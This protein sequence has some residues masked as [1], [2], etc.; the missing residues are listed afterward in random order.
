[1]ALVPFPNQASPTPV[2][3]DT[4]NDWLD[5]DQGGGGKMSFLE[6]LD[7]LRKR[8]IYSAVAL[9]VGFLIAFAFNNYIFDF[10]MRPLRAPLPKGQMLI[11]TEPM[12]AFTLRIYMSAIAGLLIATPVVMTQVWLF[13]AP[14]LYQHDKKM[15]VPHAA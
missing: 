7:E 11:F 10:V 2:E 13:V 1:M 5:S 6:H 4:D 15:A 8:I 12:E 9:G 14:R 3:D